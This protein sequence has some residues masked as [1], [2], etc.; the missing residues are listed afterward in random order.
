MDILDV[1]DPP[2]GYRYILVIGD[3]F[4]KWME[5]F[6]INNDTVANVLVE[7]IILRFCMPLVIHSDQGQEFQNGLY[8]DVLKL[9]GPLTD[10]SQTCHMTSNMSH[11]VVHV[12]QR[13]A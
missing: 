9:G 3:Y 5:A 13:L 8:W 12:R 7:K 2:A 10:Q 11:D 4:S 6:P 1:C